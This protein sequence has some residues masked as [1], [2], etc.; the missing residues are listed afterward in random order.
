VTEVKEDYT[1]TA[2]AA[3]TGAI[4]IGNITFDEAPGTAAAKN[5]VVSTDFQVAY[6]NDKTGTIPTGILLSVAGPAVVG[7]VTLG[8]ISYL[9]LKNKKRDDEEE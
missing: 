1:S 5:K 8:G 6:K 3:G 9:L 2:S 7:A 4:T